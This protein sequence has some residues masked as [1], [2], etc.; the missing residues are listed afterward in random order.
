MKLW[1][2]AAA[3]ACASLLLAGVGLAQEPPAKAAEAKKPV[4][5]KAAS[6]K[7]PVM[8]EKAMQEMW[9][10]LATPGDAHKWIAKGEG[11]WDAKVTMYEPDKPPTES[12]GVMES[13]LKL[14]GRWLEQQFEGSFMGQPFHGIGFL[15][16]DNAKKKYVSTWVDTM[17]TAI[18]VS[19]GTMDAT[20]KMLISN[21]M[22]DDPMLGKPVKVKTVYT[23]QDDDHGLYEMWS[24]GPDGK[25]RKQMEIA[26]TRK[27]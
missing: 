14:G 26:Y 6:A 27:K 2:A 11:S 10:K 17:S 5:T 4:A 9:T 22:M 23:V 7:A 3:V 1:N 15:G 20:G 8:D 25:P 13:K 12:T 18:M 19:E 21:S 16:Y 24:P